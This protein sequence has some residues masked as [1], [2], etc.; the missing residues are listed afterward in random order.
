MKLKLLT[1]FVL[2]SLIACNVDE[3]QP[4]AVDENCLSAPFYETTDSNS[5]SLQI[6]C[7][8]DNH[9]INLST[10]LLVYDSVWS[11]HYRC[12][13]ERFNTIPPMSSV[14]HLTSEVLTANVLAFPNLEVFRN[15]TS[16]ETSL[17]YQLRFLQNL[18]EMTL[19]N[20]SSFPDIIGDIPLET[21]KISYERTPSNPTIFVPSNLPQLKNLKEL[22]FKNMGLIILTDYENLRNLEHLSIRNTTLARI[23]STVNQWSKMKTIEM[24]AVDFRGNLSNF[25]GDMDSLKNAYFGEMELDETA[26]ENIYKAPNLKELTIGYCRI[27]PIP[28]AIGNMTSLENLIITTEQ[29]QLNNPITLPMTVGNLTNLKSIYISIHTNQFQTALFGLKN[30]LESL[31]IQDNIETVPTE[32][33]DFTVLKTLKL[34]NCGLINL[35]SE[36]QNL[37]NTLERLYL[38]GN[39]FSDATKSQIQN[40][41]PNT[42]VY[43]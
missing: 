31:A 36:I 25:F 14:T 38:S 6:T 3:N 42:E 26:Q 40:W 34:M 15:E 27:T 16:M 11:L 9:F 2:L 7:S 13:S 23:P 20:V 21:F 24:T 41:L 32:I 30:T 29:T 39:N 17:P 10:Q 8:C 4:I 5:I 33:G 35:P 12:D 1:I 22:S 19:F 28:D 37:A 43:F 18:R